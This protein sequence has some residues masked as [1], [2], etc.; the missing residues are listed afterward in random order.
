MK[1]HVNWNIFQR[2]WGSHQ[3]TFH[4]LCLDPSWNKTIKF[5]THERGV[6]FDKS[7]GK[8]SRTNRY[9]NFTAIQRQ[10]T[11]YIL[12]FCQHPTLFFIVIK[13]NLDKQ[14]QC[15]QTLNKKKIIAHQG[16]HVTLKSYK[17]HLYHAAFPYCTLSQVCLFF[18]FCFM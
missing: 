3:K 10:I 16:I 7:D 15:V 2:G 17:Y 1:L 6:P 5:V 11:D 4:R 9:G 18:L 13:T 8:V 14:I 12:Q